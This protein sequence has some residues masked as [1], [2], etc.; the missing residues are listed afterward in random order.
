M[1]LAKGAAAISDI[2][3]SYNREDQA[4][5]RRF[6]EAFAA[7]GFAVWWDGTLQSGDAY[8]EVTEK[9]LDEAKAVV[10][11]W[12]PRSVG[13]RW[14]RAEATV[15]DRNGTLIPCMIEPC[16]RPVMFE[17]TQT[18]DL[19]GW[20]GDRSSL[21][22]RTY[23]A[24]VRRLVERDGPVRAA[25]AGSQPASVAPP[26]GRPG[27]AILPIRCGGELED[28]AQGLVDEAVTTYNRY[29]Y[30]LNLVDLPA[31]AP[32]RIEASLRQSGGVFRLS[33]RL[34]EGES[35]AQIWAERLDSSLD[36]PFAA[37]E[38]LAQQLA[39][40]TAQA[41]EAVE[42]RWAM[43][44]PLQ[45]LGAYH[46]VLVGLQTVRGFTAESELEAVRILTD[47]AN[48]HPL[49]PYVLSLASLA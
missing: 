12:S 23:A 39:A 24:D 46:S 15:A 18:A 6:A 20:D 11:L 47:A 1:P 7:E 4:V 35:G 37:Q 21:V 16:R 42:T 36:D 43:A 45:D 3:I 13:S 38:D 27:L 22:W 31:G 10:V 49:D 32:Y 2:F 26:R 33:A 5:A 41:I 29:K 30:V 17:L 40:Q 48:K 34:L 28:F 19:T 14:V 9:A 8:D 25:V 44:R